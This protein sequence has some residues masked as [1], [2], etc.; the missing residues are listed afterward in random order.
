MPIGSVVIIVLTSRVA[1][2]ASTGG[3]C[4]STCPLGSSGPAALG[5]RFTVTV[6]IAQPRKLGGA[7]RTRCPLVHSHA[8]SPAQPRSFQ[9]SVR[10]GGGP[11]PGRAVLGEQVGHGAGLLGFLD[12]RR[13][14]GLLR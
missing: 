11:R 12:L 5:P 9:N 13:I 3:S 1:G 8:R 4:S 7:T 6:L 10:L 14:L 2:S